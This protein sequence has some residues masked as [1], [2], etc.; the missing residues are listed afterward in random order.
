MTKRPFIGLVPL[1]VAVA[2]AMVPTVAQAA[3]PHYFSE[4]AEI[5]QGEKVPTIDWG[6]TT[7]H[8]EQTGSEISCHNAIGGY[9]ENPVGGGAGIDAIEAF[10]TWDCTINYECPAGTRG[11]VSP[12]LLPWTSALVEVSGKIRSLSSKVIGAGGTREVI[13]CTAPIFSNPDFP[14]PPGTGELEQGGVFVVGAQTSD[15]LAPAGAKKGTGALHPG[16]FELDAASGLLEEEEPNESGHGNG[17]ITLKFTGK[18]F[19]LGFEHQE[20]IYA[21]N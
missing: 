11:G 19:L 6:N 2:F 7:V 18:I 5:P 10:A 21:E 9:V 20:H 13:G 16:F 14:E 15:P 12:S 4:G 3:T 8:G 17:T 1:L